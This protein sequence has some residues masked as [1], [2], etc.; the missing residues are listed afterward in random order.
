MPAT[1]PAESLE[2]VLVAAERRGV[3]RV[4]LL[5]ALDI[6]EP[7]GPVAYE[8]LAAAYE[9]AA[10]LAG[11]AAFG[12]HAGEATPARSYGLVG[13]AAANSATFGDALARILELQALRSRGAGIQLIRERGLARLV[14]RVETALPAARRRQE[15]EHMLATLLAFARDA[16]AVPVVPVEVRFAHRAP[17]DTT[18][19]DRLFGCSV[20]FGAEACEILF[21]AALLDQPLPAADLALGRIVAEQANAELARR[22]GAEP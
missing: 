15:S 4:E 1:F 22:A 11:D 3:G 18:E 7:A 10:R 2:T 19:Q 16:L 8:L 9:Q 13:Y 6:A 20:R 17:P 12:L 5:R 21:A 14:Y